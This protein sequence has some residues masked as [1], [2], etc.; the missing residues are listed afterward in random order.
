ME[1]EESGAE[2]KGEKE[3]GRGSGRAMKIAFGRERRKK[4]GGRR[5]E[6]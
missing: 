5:R 1:G 6:R 4:E 2:E 3:R